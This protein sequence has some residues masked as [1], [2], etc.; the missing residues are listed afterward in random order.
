MC[1]KS[2]PSQ[3]G[4]ACENVL[5]RRSARAMRA[6]QLMTSVARCSAAARPSSAMSLCGVVARCW[7]TSRDVTAAIARCGCSYRAMCAI[8]HAMYHS[9]HAMC[10]S[11]RAMFRSYH[12]MCHSNRAMCHS[13]RVMWPTSCKMWSSPI[14][15]KRP[16]IFS[17][18]TVYWFYKTTHKHTTHIICVSVETMK[19]HKHENK[20][21]RL[22]ISTHKA[23]SNNRVSFIQNK[24]EV[25]W[26][27]FSGQ[28]DI[29]TSNVL[30][31][32]QPPP[33]WAHQR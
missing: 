4:V 33:T 18:Y 1:Y 30:S 16:T 8:H 10:H 15:N 23:R 17:G 27:G 3:R 6:L 21:G 2:Y 20:Y 29:V 7:I 12:A 14:W 24:N 9:Y 32:I 13:Y 5:W 22:S 28:Y 11:C 19:H 26:T 25:V 31:T